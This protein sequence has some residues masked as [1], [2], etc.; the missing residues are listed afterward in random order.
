MFTSSV[1][2]ALA[3]Y[4][5]VPVDVDPDQTLEGTAA[6]SWPDYNDRMW[7]LNRLFEQLHTDPSLYDT[8]EVRS[9]LDL[10]WLDP[11]VSGNV[12]R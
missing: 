2:F 11:E 10:S 1:P 12:A 8:S 9:G 3:D 7:Y 5:R 6:G 4:L